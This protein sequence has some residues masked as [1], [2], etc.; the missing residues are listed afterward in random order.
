MTEHERLAASAM[1]AALLAPSRRKNGPT[2]DR[3]LPHTDLVRCLCI[4]Q[5][6][7]A[8]AVKRANHVSLIAQ[9]MATPMASPSFTPPTHLIG[10]TIGAS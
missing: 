5:L 7:R 2:V 1:K 9:R 10:Q 8:E 4:E 6:R 3:W